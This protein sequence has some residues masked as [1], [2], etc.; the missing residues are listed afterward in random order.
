MPLETNLNVAPYYDDFDETKNFHRVLFRPG[1]A[2]QA[3]ELTQLQTILQNQ[4][5]RFGDNIFK[6]GTIIDGCELSID[7]RYNYIKILDNQNDGQPVS[8]G[9]YANSLVV[10][11]SSN[12][13]SLVVNYKTGLESQSPNLNTLYIKYINTGSG[14]EKEYSAGQTLKVF[15]RNRTVESI[16]INNGG[17]LYN[18]S[19]LV[20]I[21]GGSG[22]GATATLT[23]DATGTITDV[24]VLSKGSGYIS[25]PS[26]SI[27]NSTGGTTT[28]TGGAFTALNYIAQITVGNNSINSVGIGTG[29][30]VSDGIIYQK[31]HFVRVSA[32]EEVVEKYNN[33]PNNKVIGFSTVET[34]VNSNSDSSLLDLATGTPNFAAP[35]ANRLKLTPAITI[36]TREQAAAN[37]DFL[38]L[39]EFENGR[40]VRDRLTT[41]FNA[42]ELE[43][44][45][46]TYEESGNY[47]LDTIKLDTEAVPGGANSTHF[48][49]VVG[50]GVAYVNGF[51]IAT[52]NNRRFAVEKA[53]TFSN[54]VSQTINTSYGNYVVVKEFLGIF[55]ISTGAEVSLR[56]AAAT[57]ITDNAGGAPTNPGSQIGTARVRTVTYES[58]IPGTPDCRYRIYLFNINMSRGYSF[59]NVRAISYTSGSVLAVADTVLTGSSATLRDVET[60]ILVFNTGANAV[61]QLFNVEYTYRTSSTGTF[62]TA[63]SYSVTI[64]SPG[65]VAYGTSGALSDSVKEN[66]IVIP[67]EDIAHS[68]NSQGTVTTSTVTIT[69]TGSSFL[70]SFEIG[71]YV[72][73][74]N[75]SANGSGYASLNLSTPKRVVNITSDTVMTVDS[76]I[77]SYSANGIY[78]VYPKNV[79]IDLTKNN[80]TVTIN[81]ANSFTVDI[82]P[83]IAAESDF[84]IFYD[85]TEP[86]ASSK[87][88]TYV[89]DVYVKLSTDKLA[90]TLTGPWCLGIP[91]VLSITGVY[92][93]TSNTYANN[94]T[95][96][97][98]EF[99]LD[100]GQRDTHYGLAYLKK[101]PGSTLNLTTTNNLLVK[102]NC[103]THQAGKF[104]AAQSYSAISEENIPIYTSITSGEVFS[105]RDCLDLRPIVSNNAVRSATEAGASIDPS[106]TETYSSDNKYF[107]APTEPVEAIIQSYLGRVD[108]IVMNDRGNVKAIKGSPGVNPI[109]PLPEAGTMDLGLLSVA[110]YPSLTAKE[111]DAANRPDLKNTITLLQTKRYTMKDIK[112]IEDRIKRLEYYTVL[113]VLESEVAGLTIPSESDPTIEVFKNG[114]FVDPFDSYAI[115]NINDGEYKALVD[116]FN[117]KLIPLQEAY[118]VDLKFD[119]SGSTNVTRTGELLTLSFTEKEL[120]KQPIANKERTLVENF[121]SFKGKM[122]VVPAVD[123]FFDTNVKGTSSIDIDIASPILALQNATNRVLAQATAA[124][125]LIDSV[126]ST[127]SSS[128]TSGFV[129]TTTFTRNTTQTLRDSYS[130]VISAPVTTTVQKTQN[131]LTSAVLDNYVRPQKLSLFV[132][133]LRP[134]A[135]HYIFFDGEDLTSNSIP[136]VVTNT[137]NL[138]KESFTP[139]YSKTSAS[140]NL[141][142]NSSGELAI[143]LDIPADT[144][145]IGEKT[146]LVMDV[147]TLSSES[148]AT[149]KAVGKFSAF[150]SKG[151][152]EG[153]EFR[154]RSFDLN[155]GGFSTREFASTRLVSGTDT[156]SVS[157]DNTPPPADV[158]SPPQD[159]G[160]GGDGGGDGADPLAQSFLVQK[161]QGGEVLYLTS[162]DVYFKEKDADKGVTLELLQV[163]DSGYPTAQII[164]FSRVYKKSSEVNTSSTAATPTTFTFS[165]PVTVNVNKEYAFRLTPDG[166]SP[167]Y[168]VWIAETGVA[169]VNTPTL[170]SNKTWGLGTLFT[171]TSSRAYSAI[172]DE[173]LKFT[174]KYADFT[175]S[176]GT[177]VITNAN[178]EFLTINAVSGSF[179]GGETVGQM[180]NTYL[181]LLL[182]TNTLSNFIS[183]NTDPSSVISVNDNVLILYGTANTAAK[184][185]NV[186]STGTTV[187]NASSTTTD[188]TVDYAV[189]SFI[190]IGREARLIT[191]IANAISLEVDASFNDTYTSENHYGVTPKFD[192]LKVI[193]A[194]TTGILVDRPPAYSTNATSNNVSSIQKV[195]K[196]TVYYYNST[197]GIMHISDSTASSNTKKIFTSNTTSPRYLVGDDSD[198]LAKVYSIDNLT[199]GYFTPLINTLV[200]PGTVISLSANVTTTSGTTSSTYN[201]DKKNKIRSNESAL[202]KSL[203]NE[204]SA[205]NSVVTKS[206]QMQLNFTTGVDDTSPAIDIVPCS[207]VSIRNII[208]N[209]SSNENTRYGN[210]SS[211]YISKRLELAD[212]LDAEDVRVYINA[213]RPSGTD[214][215]VY[216]KILNSSD[217]ESFDDKDWSKLVMV[218]NSS[219][220]SSSNDERDIHEYEFTFKSTPSTTALVGTVSVNATSAN[221]TGTG[222]TFSVDFAVG[223]VIKI[224]Y[225]TGNTDIIPITT[226]GSNTS[227]QL[228]STPSVAAPT[229]SVT[230]EKVINKKEAFKYNKNS[231]IVRYF[232]S[233]GA[234]YDSYKFMAIKI[235]LKAVNEHTVPVVDD[236][237]AIAVSV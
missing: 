216:A 209:N 58:G 146:I 104:I 170:K 55:D 163:S 193:S 207:L 161:Q 29:V 180:S 149:S 49:V 4:V 13:Q 22:T 39:I 122:Y 174:V 24:S 87:T 31:G 103:F 107:P 133:G 26:V 16:T 72:A 12:L 7:T 156:W 119:S 95:N 116:T 82:G 27:T 1:V 162:I 69:G 205:T 186:K 3:R 132:N 5:E 92:V 40:V 68:S 44:V 164:P 165:S 187:T 223:D 210:A 102:L 9:L 67:S 101:A 192:I 120:L 234:V 214:V 168:R 18:N 86:N 201:L 56:S 195:V 229:S 91:D 20:V 63:G 121:W 97:V 85:V 134:G 129:T 30:K 52:L 224:N 83:D 194:N 159:G 37:N 202:I 139:L 236:V 147:S 171:S 108:R 43:L 125:A 182:T 17:T 127:T 71:D 124:T 110:P 73:V 66:I 235:V 77:G 136:A 61:K 226:I 21:S 106:S 144:F 2:V 90:N 145:T 150:S 36:L 51:R 65:T 198:A 232:G 178:N 233:T 211:K 113:N 197:K 183:T 15:N 50:S 93:G 138:T 47:V 142:A 160:T 218:T 45:K 227:M 140:Q 41:Q 222:T 100:N 75:T 96:Y 131:Y 33:Q 167:S 123:N 217:N 199:T 135:R 188:F 80:K 115:S 34:L 206:L 81:S 38:P 109:P 94:T 220:Y 143:I 177:A 59:A 46:R 231:N 117:S 74:G 23:T 130:Q 10:Q 114:F 126:S 213:Y 62:T 221:V 42:V 203:S 25:V 105:L 189:G 28:G 98:S 8:L 128:S 141:V 111:A 176:T 208:N 137:S 148:S 60:D 169:D 212:D 215:E 76:S 19:D 179:V 190:R 48:N 64:A 191:S 158:W 153:I 152:S 166:N 53:N 228:A 173:D 112:D 175:N 181:S 155:T 230:Y 79:P 32:Q 99:E 118:N 151:T 57:D 185:A 70:S 6:T 204:I 172:Q 200:L 78:K 89:T 154:T 157:V 35:G 237:R 88:K 196:G 184:T 84:T 14:L 11:E 54:T 219:K 225:A